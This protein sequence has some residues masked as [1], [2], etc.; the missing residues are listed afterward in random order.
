MAREGG[1]VAVVLVGVLAGD[2]DKAGYGG[3]SLD[4][5]EGVVAAQWNQLS[6]GFVLS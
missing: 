1:P 2:E 5:A 3:V 4:G 6:Y